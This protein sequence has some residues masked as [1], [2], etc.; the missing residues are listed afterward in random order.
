MCV[1]D[2]CCKIMKILFLFIYERGNFFYRIKYLL[3]GFTE[4]FGN[5]KVSKSAY[6]V[7]SE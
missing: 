4:I 1:N 7:A 6:A 2:G 5:D 3:K